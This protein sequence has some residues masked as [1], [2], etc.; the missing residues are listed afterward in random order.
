MTNSYKY[1]MENE[2][3]EIHLEIN[4]KKNEYIIKKW[5]NKKESDCTSNKRKN[6]HDCRK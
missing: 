1:R 5:Y 2:E 3:K 6:K 4:R